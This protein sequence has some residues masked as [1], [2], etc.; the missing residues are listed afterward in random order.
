MTRNGKIARLPK[1]IRDRLNQQILDGVPGKNLVAWLNEKIEV[2]ILLEEYFNSRPITEQNL[3]EWKQGGHQDW[4][5]HQEIR[6]RVR[7]M[8]EEGEDL[9]KEAGQMPLSDRHAATMAMALGSALEKLASES[10]DTPAQRRELLELAHEL[11]RL[12][13][14]DYRSVEL[15]M[16]LERF[17]KAQQE[18]EKTHKETRAWRALTKLTSWRSTE[19]YANLMTQ[20]YT[21]E[22][23]AQFRESWKQ[24]INWEIEL[25][26]EDDPGF[27]SSQAKDNPTES[28]SIQPD[29]T[30]FSAEAPVT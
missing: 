22:Q 10:F 18:Q 15:R 11:S 12:R 16:E 19:Q 1:S 6:D 14:T 30:P 5:K 28:D 29:P 21:P 8:G 24:E 27:A 3:S 13:K 9:A 26:E 20:G 4:L 2:Q 25:E 23:L 7:L 17:K